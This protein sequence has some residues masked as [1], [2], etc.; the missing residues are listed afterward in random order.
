M[1]ALPSGGHEAPM[2]SQDTMAGLQGLLSGI[3][4]LLAKRACSK[5]TARE[6]SSSPCDQRELHIPPSQ[7]RVGDPFWPQVALPSLG[8]SLGSWAGTGPGREL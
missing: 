6:A 8:S 3:R 1:K 5:L 4:L 7:L 2:K